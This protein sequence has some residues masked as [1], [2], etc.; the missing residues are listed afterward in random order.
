MGTPTFPDAR[1]VMLKRVRLSFTD[2][3]LRP[4]KPKGVEDA[5]E[6]Y[7]CNIINERG[8]HFDAN[9]KAIRA[10]MS[11]A[12]QQFKGNPDLYKVIIEKDAKRVAYRKGERFTNDDGKIYDGY[13]GNFAISGKGP[14]G[15]QER[16]TLKD[17]R[18]RD[19]TDI[20]KDIP[21][22]CYSGSYADVIVSFYGTDKGGLGIFCSIE[23][24]RSHEEGDHLGG[25][26]VDV[27]DD[28]FDD[29]P[30]DDS[31]D[32]DTGGAS[33]SDDTDGLVG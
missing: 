11:E 24:I 26:R 17:R 20:D 31:F 29:L 2:T 15:G 10:A 3:L 8:D 14:R 33:S 18:K 13:E 25:S 27:T 9:D 22:V 16:P 32:D 23:A 7:G 21:T 12:G 19:I 1:T 30:D 5:K 4:G 28:M 6:S